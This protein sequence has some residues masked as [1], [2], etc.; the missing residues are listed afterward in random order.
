MRIEI[1]LDD[2]EAESFLTAMLL[3]N[4]TGNFNPC[5]KNNPKGSITDVVLGR[6]ASKVKKD[7]DKHAK[8]QQQ[9]FHA[10]ESTLRPNQPAPHK[11]GEESSETQWDDSGAS[12]EVLGLNPPPQAEGEATGGSDGQ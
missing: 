4:W 8:A 7:K 3:L 1:E 5:N 10:S 12:G 6:V 11:K 2:N 9:T